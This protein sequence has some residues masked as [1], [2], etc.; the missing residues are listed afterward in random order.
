MLRTLLLPVE[1]EREVF[2]L[3]ELLRE[4]AA[5]REAAVAEEAREAEVAEEAREA[6]VEREAEDDALFTEE[7][8]TPELLLREEEAAE[9]VRLPDR[10]DVLRGLLELP[11]TE[12]LF[13]SLWPMEAARDSCQR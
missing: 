3:P 7:E 8:R 10:A 4:L 6:E 2:T 13:P 1:L 12:A 9:R 11:R 5:E